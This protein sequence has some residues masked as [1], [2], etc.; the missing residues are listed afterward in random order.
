VLPPSRRVEQEFGDVIYFSCRRVQDEGPNTFGQ[1]SAAR[2]SSEDRCVIGLY[3][4]IMQPLGLR[5]GAGPVDAFEDKEEGLFHV[6]LYRKVTADAGMRDRSVEEA[7]SCLSVWPSRV[8]R[9]RRR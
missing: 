7:L 4:S 1:R 2:F 3:K 6:S 9:L 8:R 5:G